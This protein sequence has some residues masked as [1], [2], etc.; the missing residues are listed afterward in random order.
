MFFLRL[1]LLITFG[2]FC[3]CQ[4]PE[5]VI[6]IAGS[7]TVLPVIEKAAAAYSKL[8][9]HIRI[10]INTGGSG[11]GVNQIGLDKIDI[12]MISRDI[13]VDEIQAFPKT[14]FKTIIVG[15]DAV[16]PVVSNEIYEQGLIELDLNTIGDIYRGKIK[17]W[18]DLGLKPNEILV[19]DKEASRGT[20][21]VFMKAILGNKNARAIGVDLVLGHN[22]EV[23]TAI[24]QS[25]QA[26]GMLSFAWL[27]PEVK[28]L[29]IKNIQGQSIQANLTTIKLGKYPI[30]RSLGLLIDVNKP[31]NP[32]V[33]SFLNYLLSEAGQAIV[34]ELKYIP[35]DA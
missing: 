1:Y 31:L 15:K 30:V 3:S 34:R 25:Q 20:R 33:E 18:Q 23:Q 24:A 27:S 10:Q 28:A 7:S 22:N 19:I 26:I 17:N 9:P 6:R 4:S 14:D 29:A 8:H 5:A 35:V 2:L 32:D 11:I 13:S 12:G 16:V 21:Q